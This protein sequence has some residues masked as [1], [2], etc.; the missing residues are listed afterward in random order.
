MILTTSAILNI[1]IILF[2][3]LISG[4]SKSITDISSSPNLFYKSR[5]YLKYKL[6]PKFWE[7]GLG[8]LN[9]YKNANPLNG[10]KFI[11][12][13]TIFVVFTD[14]WHL[15]WFISEITMILASVIIT[16]NTSIWFVMLAFSIKLIFFEIVFNYLRKKIN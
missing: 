5:L 6:N 13:T 7:Q 2:L 3:L 10:E 12:S 9:K 8:S 4:I 11:G 15:F 16:L 1:L 14:A